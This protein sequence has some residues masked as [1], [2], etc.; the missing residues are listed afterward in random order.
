MKCNVYDFDKTIFRKD[1]S[2]EFYKFCLKKKP[3]IL[4]YIFIQ[5]F[6]FVLYIFSFIN[7]TKFK[8][9]V[10]VFLKSFNDIDALVKEFWE[11][12]KDKVRPFYIK[13][14]QDSDIVISASPYFLLKPICDELGIKHLIAS[15]VDSKTGKFLRPN[16]YGEEKVKRLKEQ[17]DDVEI[18]EFYSDSFSDQPLAD[19][20]SESFIIKHNVVYKWNEYTPTLKDKIKHR[21]FS[22]EFLAFLIV[23]FINTLNGVLFSY[24]F[25]LFLNPIIAFFV[26]YALSL[27]ISYLL[28]SFLVFKS[29]LG[30]RKYVK[31]C[32]SYMPN[33]AIQNGLILVFYYLLHFH[34]LLV[35]ALAA[36]IAIPITFL[37]LSL[38]TFKRNKKDAQDN[39]TQDEI[40]VP[41]ICFNI[42]AIIIMTLTIDVLVCS[43]VFFSRGV[44]T[45]AILPSSFVIAC[46]ILFFF[47][48]NKQPLTFLIEVCASLVI[49]VGFAMLMG[50]F[51]DASYDGNAYHKLAIGLLRYGWN[52][53]Y[54]VPDAS[55]ATRVLGSNVYI[56]PWVEGYCKGTWFFSATMYSITG[57]IETGKCYNIILLVAVFLV[58]YGTYRKRINCVPAVILLAIVTAFNPVLISQM[59]TFYLDGALYASLALLIMYLLVWLLDEKES[60]PYIYILIGAAMVFCG[61][62]KF[63]GLL[64]GGVFCIVNYLAY[65][66]RT[67]A[68]NKKQMSNKETFKKLIPSF[69]I[70]A[71]IALVTVI[72]GGSSAYVTNLIRH[73][74][75]GY[76]ITGKD[77]ID[78]MTANSPFTPGTDRFTC[79]FQSLFAKTSNFVYTSGSPIKLKMPF[80][81]AE[82]ELE[83]LKEACDI[84]L[85]GFGPLFSGVVILTA[86]VFIYECIVG[87]K[88][89]ENLLLL[90]NFILCLV[91]VIA[92]KESWWARYSAYAYIAVIIVL[93]AAIKD[94]KF[95]RPLIYLAL[96]TAIVLLVNDCY[97]FNIIKFNIEY[98][99]LIKESLDAVKEVGDIHVYNSFFA[100]SYFNLMDQGIKFVIDPAVM[101]AP[102]GVILPIG[103]YWIKK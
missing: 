18:N 23:G 56:E 42:A 1:S 99:Q 31:F 79:L 64:L 8:E 24:L 54:E 46:S 44:I 47:K 70:F 71:S 19:L 60:R 21:F 49:F 3:S 51:Y 30:F 10:F 65:V 20:A 73:Q 84:R 93:Y 22:K 43:L 15:E 5:L 16:C 25:S 91:F 86:C 37:V 58:A 67:F 32:I 94:G 36:I 7:K 88:N 100:G 72:W 89:Y 48:G 55:V 90:I 57:N 6:Y 40:N 102:E 11:K 101:D 77:A 81:V 87:K 74:T 27:S 85:S 97:S 98:S 28:N 63:T 103:T 75:I 35:Y 52:P 82:S 41:S 2:V 14:H 9:H 59:F 76:P 95:T 39:N 96:L 4:K 45:A 62:V 13:Q 83:Y 66:V 17:F 61:N 68:K 38:V 29:R 80:T 50:Q 92:I 12:N 78:I 26:G 53:I 33:F 34:K 69:V